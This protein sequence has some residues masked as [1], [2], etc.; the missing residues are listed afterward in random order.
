VS[1]T[2]LKRELWG[3]VFENAMENAITIDVDRDSR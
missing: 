1:L 3:L 2:I